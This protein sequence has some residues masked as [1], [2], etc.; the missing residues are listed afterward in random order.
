MNGGV[1]RRGRDIVVKCDVTS[2]TCRL[3]ARLSLGEGVRTREEGEDIRH[4][5][6]GVSWPRWRGG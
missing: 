5:P 6:P 3:L 2:H 4:A 1:W